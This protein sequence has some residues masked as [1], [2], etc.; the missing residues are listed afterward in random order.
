ME[1][2]A[3]RLVIEKQAGRESPARTAGLGAA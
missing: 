1:A 2:S 3:A